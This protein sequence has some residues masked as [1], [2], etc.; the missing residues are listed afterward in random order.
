MTKIQKCIWVK[1]RIRGEKQNLEQ[2]VFKQ[3]TGKAGK[4]SLL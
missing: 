4:E 2:N 1:K 3:T